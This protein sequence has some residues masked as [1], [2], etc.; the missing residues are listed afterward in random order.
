MKLLENCAVEWRA[1]GEVTEVLRGKRLVRSQLS[2]SEKFPVFHGGLEPLG[3]YG[4]SNRPANTVMVINV[5]AS[6]G[7]VGYSAVDFWSSD[8]CFC[9][10][11]S[12]LLNNRFLYYVLVG[13]QHFLRSKVRVAGIPTLD[14]IVVEKLQIPIP[15]L[16]IQREIVRI[17]DNFTELNTELNT[18]LAAR[19]KQYAYYRD[20]LLSYTTPPCGHPSTGGEYPRPDEHLAPNSPPLEGWQ[21]Q[22]DGVVSVEWKTLGEVFDILAG[23]DAPKATLSEIETE[24]FNVPILSNGIG[25]KSLYGWTNVAKIHEPSLTISARGTIGW[26]SYRDTPFFPI[27]RLIVL[28]P[29]VKVNLKYAYYFM[30]T[31]EDDYN[32]PQ[33]GIPQLTKPMV[34][35]IKI[36]IPPLAEQARIVAIL[37]QFDA[38]TS[39]ITEGLPREIELRQKQYEYYREQLLSFKNSPP[40][41][42]WQAQ[43]DGVV[44]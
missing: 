43:P 1:L 42:G 39:S 41:E 14:A 29:K 15:P 20:A 36:P 22:P 18:E 2:D 24:E 44:L 23:G 28:T 35:D 30:K 5:G 31:I 26:T 34:K 25:V 33:N 6:A 3:F 13:H 8:G 37:D 32:V 38:L 16:T 17:L 21:A 12:N 40:A 11:P 10:A 4:D 7:T 9:I 19:K 27:V